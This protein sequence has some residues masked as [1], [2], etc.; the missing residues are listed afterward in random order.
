MSTVFCAITPCCSKRAQHVLR[1]VLFNPEDGDVRLS[2]NCT[3]LQSR[4]LYSSLHILFSILCHFI[5]LY[6]LIPFVQSFTICFSLFRLLFLYFLSHF[7]I[8]FFYRSFLPSLLSFLMFL[9]PFLVSICSF[10]YLYFIFYISLFYFFLFFLPLFILH[11]FISFFICLLLSFPTSIPT[12]TFFNLC[13]TVP[14]G[15]EPNNV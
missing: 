9:P 15:F 1:T 7:S 6:V 4:R 13:K 3:A 11:Y 14:A 12:I 5:S 8:Y 10:P 2:A